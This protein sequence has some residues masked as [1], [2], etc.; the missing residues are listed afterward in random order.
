MCVV[1]CVCWC[2][3]GAKC[4]KCRSPITSTVP[5]KTMDAGISDC[6]GT[7][8]TAAIALVPPRPPPPV[9]TLEHKGENEVESEDDSEEE[10][11]ER[12]KKRPRESTSTGK[13]EGKSDG[14][15]EW[16]CDPRAAGLVTE[17]QD[18]GAWT[19]RYEA[20]EAQGKQVL[21]SSAQS[22]VRQAVSSNM[23]PPA[24]AAIRAAAAQNR[25]GVQYD[26]SMAH[27]EYARSGRATCVVCR[28]LIANRAL[29][30]GVL[31]ETDG[32]DYYEPSTSFMH[33]ECG[34]VF[35][36]SRALYTQEGLL[37][38]RELQGLQRLSA[39]DRNIVRQ[40]LG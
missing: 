38:Y 6:L 20:N 29:R 8:R 5:N 32:Y 18:L 13:G 2:R 31:P 27:V 36:A 28:Q 33:L 10:E 26:G 16:V 40:V 1:C 17:S 39:A 35:N 23:P 34:P 22:V 7:I 3:S 11:E 15:S 19:E 12:R 37:Q 4:P 14:S 30:F 21:A 24:A 25:V 9:S